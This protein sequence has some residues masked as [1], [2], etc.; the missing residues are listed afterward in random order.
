MN[1]TFLSTESSQNIKDFSYSFANLS[2]SRAPSTKALP[3]L[4]PSH[5][6]TF[7]TLPSIITKKA[8]NTHRK[9]LSSINPLEFK[10]EEIEIKAIIKEIRDRKKGYI[11]RNRFLDGFIGEL[12]YQEGNNSF[13][14]EKRFI[15]ELEEK[16]EKKG[17]C[18]SGSLCMVF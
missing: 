6:R 16:E 5:R 3:E 12:D 1:N 18:G 10:R 14:N 9:T 11:E 2:R 15:L 17:L 13:I 7:S 4:S 8:H